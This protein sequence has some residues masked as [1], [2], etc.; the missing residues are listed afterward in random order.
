MANGDGGDI[1]FGVDEADRLTGFEFQPLP[2][3]D[4]EYVVI[5]RVA[6][7]LTAPHQLMTAAR[8]STFGTAGAST[9]W[10]SRKYALHFF[11]LLRL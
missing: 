6:P 7:S 4:D 11:L 5:L 2:V 9:Q 10:I 3:S 8:N 1:I